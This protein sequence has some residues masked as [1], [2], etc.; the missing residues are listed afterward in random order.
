[1]SQ[2]LR[3]S[4]EGK[5]WSYKTEQQCIDNLVGQYVMST[6]IKEINRYTTDHH[7]VLMGLITRSSLLT[8]FCDI[9]NRNPL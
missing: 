1:M 4:N 8:R 5:T 9:S 3:V 2:R 7:A 6:F